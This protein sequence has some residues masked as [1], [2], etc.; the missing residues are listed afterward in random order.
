MYI[1][2]PVYGNHR[3]LELSAE[4]IKT[5]HEDF[6]IN[7]IADTTAVITDIALN[8]LKI[9]NNVE[10]CTYIIFV[11]SEQK[12]FGCSKVSH[13]TRTTMQQN[14]K[15]ILLR[16]IMTEAEKVFLVQNN[17]TNIAV[18]SK[19]DISQTKKIKKALKMADIKLL[20]H[21]IINQDGNVYSF[22]NSDLKVF[23]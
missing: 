9:Q 3:S 5:K 21:L 23:P 11:D 8:T 4:E 14:V 20:D 18:P 22:R 10:I 6:K 19:T 17:P 7:S 13:G 16:A 12:I 15:N 1:Y 2:E